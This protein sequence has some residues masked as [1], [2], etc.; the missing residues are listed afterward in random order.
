MSERLS[1][2]VA[3]TFSIASFVNSLAGPLK[4]DAIPGMLGSPTVP[5]AA[6]L[7]ASLAGGRACTTGLIAF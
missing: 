1:G 6:I 4:C 3:I 7:D 5:G 2:L